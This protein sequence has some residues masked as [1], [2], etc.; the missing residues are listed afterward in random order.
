MHALVTGSDGFIGRHFVKALEQRGATVTRCDPHSSGDLRSDCL[1]L[2]AR[3]AGCYDLVVHCAAFVGGRE[4]IE[5]EAFRLATSNLTLDAAMFDWARRTQTKARIVY[6]SSSAVYPIHLQQDDLRSA[7]SL[8]EGDTYMGGESDQSYGWVKSVG[9][10][11]AEMARANGLDVQVFRPFSGYGE[12]QSE[13][14]PF[15]ALVE[16][17]K[18]RE[19]VIGIWGSGRQVRDWVHVDDIVGA[20]LKWYSDGLKFDGPVNIASGIGTSMKALVQAMVFATGDPSY[21]P[22]LAM[23][24]DKPSGV[25]RRVGDP[26]KLDRFYERKVMLHEGIRR[27]MAA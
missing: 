17:V 10:Q 11:L 23:N 2:F 25:F 18:R 22:S 4:A 24:L 14:Y 9:E 19:S 20:V 1:E 8:T 16:R 12:D 7:C 5:G 3:N 21:R 6:F 26:A 13:D 27:A 15:R